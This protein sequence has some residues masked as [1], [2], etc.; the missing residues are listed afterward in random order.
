M[1]PKVIMR[2]P[3]SSAM[4]RPASSA[5][6]IFVSTPIGKTISLMLER[7]DNIGNVKAKIQ[8][9]TGISCDDQVLIMDD[10]K[11]TG[12]GLASAYG[13]EFGCTLHLEGGTVI[14]VTTTTS[15]HPFR[16]T[17]L[18]LM[19]VEGSTIGDIKAQIQHKVGINVG[20]QRLRLHGGGDCE[21]IDELA[22]T[23]CAVVHGS[24]LLLDHP[25]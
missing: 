8:D 25:W 21:L 11:I 15:T 1:A 13:I 5:G 9:C 6:E 14:E 2:R 12:C 3:A 10:R 23:A 16:G 18:L 19:V 4:R 22:V 24:I 20:L 7:G 17:S